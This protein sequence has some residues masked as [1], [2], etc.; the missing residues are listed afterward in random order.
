MKA[1][2]TSKGLVI[3]LLM[4]SGFLYS[5]KD[6]IIAPSKPQN[7]V[8][9]PGD[10]IVTITWDLD[11]NATM[12]N[13][14][15]SESA[16]LTTNNGTLI[17][18][19]ISPYTHTGRS[20]GTTYYYIVTAL[21]KGG[22]SPASEEVSATLL[23]IQ[24]KLNNGETPLEIYNGNNNLLDSLYGKSYQ[25]GLIF[26]FNTQDGTGLVTTSFDLGQTV[27]GCYG[28]SISG[29]DGTKIGTGEQ[30]TLD[31][32]AGCS[33]TDIA[34]KLCSD[35]IIGAYNDWYL[36]SKDELNM[37]WIKAGSIAANGDDF[38]VGIGYWSSTEIDSN[39][40]LAQ[41]LSSGYQ[42]APGNGKTDLYF[43]RAIRAF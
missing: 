11:P 32:L 23:T 14:Y 3:I 31:I 2:R 24:Q 38:V 43:V 21:N 5:C 35:L 26:Y 41:D 9:I 27:W 34:A 39:H 13:I 10:E 16:G 7:V 33:E 30:N 36:P 17:S 15:W 19:V 18:N 8:A 37:L 4:T 29:A 20:S 1:Q 40:A 22:E 28:T 25:G 12:Y 42:Y 6:E